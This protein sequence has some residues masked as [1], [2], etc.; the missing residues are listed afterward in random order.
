MDEQLIDGR[1]PPTGDGALGGFCRLQLFIELKGY[2][3]SE[4]RTNTV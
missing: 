4:K 1:E 3:Q 2:F